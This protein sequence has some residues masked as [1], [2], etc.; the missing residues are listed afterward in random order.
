VK[1]AIKY[2]LR[3]LYFLLITIPVCGGKFTNKVQSLNCNKHERQNTVTTYFIAFIEICIW[4]DFK[5]AQ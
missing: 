5:L 4:P 1:I 2:C 3:Y